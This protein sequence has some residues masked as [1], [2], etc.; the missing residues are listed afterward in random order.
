MTRGRKRGRSR[1][2]RRKNEKRTRGV[3]REGIELREGGK[4]KEME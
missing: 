4:K 3:G 2:K 1:K